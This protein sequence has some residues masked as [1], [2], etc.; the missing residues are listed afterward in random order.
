MANIQAS[1]PANQVLF[2]ENVGVALRRAGKQQRE[3]AG[4]L[5]I[6]P[7]VLSRKLN[8]LKQAY[9]TYVEIKLIIK[10]LAAWDAITTQAEAVTLLSLMGLRAQN[11]T[12]DEWQEAP[13]NKLEVAAPPHSSL[14][15]IDAPPL[16]GLLIPALP[17]PRT[18]LIGREALVQSVLSRLR[19]SSVR[20]LTLLG[21]GGVGKTRLAVAV[22]HEAR[23]EFPDGVCFVTLA[24][25]RDAA[26]A[27][28]SI[29]QALRLPEPVA[30]SSADGQYHLFHEDIL[31]RFLREKEFLLVL[32]N[33][34]QIPGVAS[35]ISELLS[36]AVNLKILVTS[37]AVQHLYGEHEFIVPTLDVC[38]P[39]HL[40]ALPYVALFP[41]IRLFVERAQFVNPAFRLTEDNAAA[42]ARICSRLDGLP[43]AVELAAARTKTLPAQVIWERLSSGVERGSAFLRQKASD[44]PRRHRTLDDALDWSYDLLDPRQQRLFRNL[45]IFSGGWTL[46]AALAVCLHDVDAATEDTALDHIES[47]INQ[48]LVKQVPF[49]K[50]FQVTY[51][52]L[53]FYFLE[54]IHE[55]A[56]RRLEAEDERD[57]AQQRHAAYFLSLAEQVAPDLAGREQSAA[58]SVLSRE[59]DNMRA[60]LEWAIGH[61]EAEIAARLCGALGRF[62]EAR[63]QFREAQHRVDAVLALPQSIAPARRAA[64][65]MVASRLALWQ[66]ACE[67]S[68]ELAQ[69]ALALYKATD[70]A[71]GQTWAIFQI[72]DTWHMQ[73]NYDLA[74]GFLIESLRLFRELPNWRGY[75]FTLSRLGA[76]ATLQGNFSQARSW[77]NEALP[78]LREYSEPIM[79]NVT[80]VYLGVLALM[81]GDLTRSMTY[82]RE[83]LLLAQHTNNRYMLATALI[84]YG[85]L[86]GTTRGP[87]YAARVCSAAESL[88]ASLN[89]ALPAAYRPLYDAYLTSIKSQIDASTWDSWW[90]EGATLSQEDAVTLVFLASETNG[91]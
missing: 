39:A 79:L 23:K 40:P 54:T 73:G 37:R 56:L 42:V 17:A 91:N 35:F 67:R 3:L 44:V 27:P 4:A 41:A 2:R 57:A 90:A 25:L 80:L 89:T 48:S 8:G 76:L 87:S 59:Q 38:D 65:L 69:D 20:L 81:Q 30:G 47:L 46:D 86:L 43:L 84:V 51:P 74:N 22:A 55:Y 83:G 19:Q 5:G 60:A 6:E 24:S 13:L 7:P 9:L 63:T 49:D 28:S 14:S 52:Q 31:K 88:F 61:G 85:C 70:D 66:V 16:T 34:E 12:G 36:S 32:D 82:L 11:F 1:S 62:W 78:L 26:L 18:S 58:L 33:V 15:T 68:R 29:V 64:L 71:D 72:G 50:D 45:S 21:P 10:T 77:L 75:A 53:R